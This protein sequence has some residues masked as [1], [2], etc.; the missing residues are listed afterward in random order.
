MKEYS[1]KSGKIFAVVCLMIIFVF[2][3]TIICRVVTRQLV[4]KKLGITNNITAAIFF[5][6]PSLNTV[7]NQP[8]ENCNSERQVSIDWIAKYPFKINDDKKM[9]DFNKYEAKVDGIKLKINDYTGKHF[10]GRLMLSKVA[11]EQNSFLQWK[12]GKGSTANDS[13]VLFMENGYLTYVQ[14][15]ESEDSIAEIANSLADF[16]GW[17]AER[18]IKFLYVNAGSKVN[19]DD[20]QLLKQFAVLEYTNENGDT[21]QKHLSDKGVAYVDMRREMKEAGLDWYSAYYRTDHHWTTATGMWAAGV[22][23]EKLDAEYGFV[24]DKKI[25]DGKKYFSDSYTWKGG[26]WNSAHSTS[27]YDCPREE[28]TYY[29]PAFPTLFSVEIPTR[30]IERQGEYKDTLIDM[31][32]VMDGKQ[33]S[34]ADLAKVPDAY[35]NAMWRNDAVGIFKNLLPVENDKKLLVLQDSFGWYLTTYLACGVKEVH[36]IHPMAFDGSIHAYIEEF[37]PDTVI[38]LYCERNIK[39]IN[40]ATHKS[41]FDFR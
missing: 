7:T 34:D 12:H 36:V 30:G 33:Y 41:A 15:K 2:F 35:H 3:A 8:T 1:R 39:K 21:L 25:F 10:L 40:W 9:P 26:Q 13:E 23:A 19:P 38:V 5:D 31:Q 29:L 24:F 22:I 20:R 37:K 27:G 4:V 18:N 32:K 14:P 6:A 11:G 17:L 16:Q 28:Y